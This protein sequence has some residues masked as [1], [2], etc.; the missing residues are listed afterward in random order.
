MNKQ[1]KMYLGLG[2]LALAAYYFYNKSKNSP[3]A[4]AEGGCP[5]GYSYSINAKNQPI[6][7]NGKGHIYKTNR[8]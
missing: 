4:N 6:C 5:A 8:K 2:V 7:D 1:T 3:K